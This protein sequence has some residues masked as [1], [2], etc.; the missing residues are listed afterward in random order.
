M[1]SSHIRPRLVVAD[2]HGNIYDHPEL[3]MIC[4]KGH[5]FSLPKPDELIPLPEGSE[6]FLLPGRKGMGLNP[7]S[8]KIEVTNEFAVAAFISPAHTLTAHAAYISEADAPVLPLFAYGALGF[9]NNR[10]YVCAKK[11]DTDQRQVFTHI[12]PE[13]ILNRAKSIQKRYPHN[14]LMQHLMERCVLQYG[15]PAARNLALGRYEAPL[16]TSRACN[17]R[18]VGCISYQGADSK[19]CASPQNRLDFVPTAD[20]ILEV[21]WHHAKNEKE[22]PIYSFGQGCEGEPLTQATLLEETIRRFRHASGPGTINL[23]TN[24]SIPEATTGLARAGLSSMRVSMSSARPEVYER[25]YR[26]QGYAFDDV[27]QSVLNAK[28]HNVFVSINLLFFPG[29]TDSEPELEEWIRFLESTRADFIQLR[30]LNIDPELYLNLLAG[31]EFGPA[32]GLA[33]FKKRLQKACPWLDFGYFNPFV[34]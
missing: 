17:A 32:M 25:Y 8:G 14:R 4:R 26:P 24:A 22:R 30:N 12:P 13:R 1:A 16:P 3:L 33:N 18:C 7:Q 19:I 6:L 20:E 21:M 34:G 27:K 2:A 11:V 31:I 15:C 9:A 28:T 10:F 29:I 5:E 23:N